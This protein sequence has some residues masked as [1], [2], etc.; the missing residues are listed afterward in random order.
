MC[1]AEFLSLLNDFGETK[2]CGAE[3]HICYGS[4]EIKLCGAELP[5]LLQD[6]IFSCPVIY[7]CTIQFQYFMCTI[8]S[9][10]ILNY[11][12]GN[13]R[14]WNLPRLF[15]T[16]DCPDYRRNIVRILFKRK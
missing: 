10:G 14:P 9:M 4:M 2:L 16:L 6:F 13:P 15:W 8:Y 7:V 11:C 12:R 3:L 5:M 1:K